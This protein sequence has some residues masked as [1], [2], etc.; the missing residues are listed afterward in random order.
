MATAANNKDEID[1]FFD[2]PEK[3]VEETKETP[4]K[5]ASKAPKKDVTP[6]NELVKAPQKLGGKSLKT[7]DAT[8]GGS[9]RH[10]KVLRDN[11]EGVTKPAIRRLARRAGV[12]RIAGNVYDKSRTVL[13]NFITMIIRDA[14]VYTE[15]SRLKTITARHIIE[16]LRRNGSTI[17]GFGLTS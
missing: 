7:M 13:K 17:Y 11:I 12:K 1:N 5:K 15:H 9:K 8:M 3:V 4:A 2:V 10:R 14:V 16:S 6:S